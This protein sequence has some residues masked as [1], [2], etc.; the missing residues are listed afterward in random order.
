MVGAGLA[1]PA[2]VD[3]LS[4]RVSNRQHTF[5]RGRVSPLAG[6]LGHSLDGL[7]YAHQMERPFPCRCCRS[8]ERKTGVS[9][10]RRAGVRALCDAPYRW[11]LLD[12]VGHFPHE[13]DP[14]RFDRELLSWLRDP[15][16]DR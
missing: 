2:D 3:D 13:E 4:S 5:L 9:S 15:E 1:R 11:R 12:G 6:A 16:P 8:M 10:R 14:E 7:R